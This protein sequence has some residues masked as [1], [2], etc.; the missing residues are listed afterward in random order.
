MIFIDSNMWCYFFDESARENKKVVEFV[1]RILEKEEVAIN[2]AVITEIAHFLIKNL[3]PVNGKKKIETFLE[4]P[5]VV[6]DVTYAD[7]KDS[8]ELLCQ[9]AHEGIGGRDA[10]LLSSMKKLGIQRIA[11][12]DAAFKKVE[13]ADVIDPIQNNNS[14]EH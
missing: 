14:K 12:H 4:F 10:T 8:I 9:Y 6:R 2:T 5:L 1:K 11:T 7:T 3:G 13:W